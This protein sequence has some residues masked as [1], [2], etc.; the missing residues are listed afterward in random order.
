MDWRE[1][2]SKFRAYDDSSSLFMTEKGYQFEHSQ[3]LKLMN[4]KQKAC[5]N[6]YF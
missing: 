2:S 1:V 3:I 6:K 4:K 5:F